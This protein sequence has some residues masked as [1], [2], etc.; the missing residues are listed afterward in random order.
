MA[1]VLFIAKLISDRDV[2]AMNRKTILTINTFLVTIHAS[3]RI[4]A[5]E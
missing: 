5:P 3:F 1:C 2:N 4:M